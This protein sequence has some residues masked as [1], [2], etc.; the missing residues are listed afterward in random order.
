VS[1]TIPSFTIELNKVGGDVQRQS[2][3]TLLSGWTQDVNKIGFDAKGTI[4]FA[5]Q[6]PL[7]LF[8][9]FITMHGNTLW[10][11]PPKP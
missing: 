2:S 6:E 1:V 11:L 8:N 5:D 9:S 7:Q 10:T 3:M 4:A